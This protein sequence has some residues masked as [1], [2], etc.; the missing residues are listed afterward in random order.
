M[1]DE[2]DEGL[3]LLLAAEGLPGEGTE[4]AFD[5]PTREWAA[6]RTGPAVNVFLYDLREDTSRRHSGAQAEH[7][8]DGMVVGRREPSRWYQLSY[9]VTAWTARL[10]DEHRLLADVLRGLSRHE[11][12]PDAWLT[13]SLAERELNVLL[14]V[15]GTVTEGVTAT[16]IWS[17]LGGQYKPSISLRVT[18]P[19]LGDLA[20]VGPAVTE[21]MVVHTNPADGDDSG[22]RLRY[23]GPTTAQG[24]GLAPARSKPLPGARVRH[25]GR[26]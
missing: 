12:M 16:D 21:G 6:K 9:L 26:L 3:R 23:D 1:I 7:D 11:S 15:G 8:D 4:L 24:T 18:A 17:S 20:P 22:R 13:G 14:D 19:L 5:P 2:V 10:N 25:R